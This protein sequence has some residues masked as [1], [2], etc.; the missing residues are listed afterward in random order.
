MVKNNKR[1]KIISF[2][3]FIENMNSA[4]EAND[5]GNDAI[6]EKQLKTFVLPGDILNYMSGSANG[7]NIM[8]VALWANENNFI[9][10]A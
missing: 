6:F 10:I 9:T 1:R 3:E 4:I 7:P 2:K 5:Y 8:K